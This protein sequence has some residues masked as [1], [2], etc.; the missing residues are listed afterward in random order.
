ME[1]LQILLVIL[2]TNQVLSIQLN[3]VSN[4]ANLIFKKTHNVSIINE[5]KIIKFE[6]NMT[7]FLL[8]TKVL[9]SNIKN[10]SN[11]CNNKTSNINCNYFNRF[12]D[13]NSNRLTNEKEHLFQEKRTKRES[14]AIFSSITNFFPCF[15]NLFDDIINIL[16]KSIEENRNFTSQLIEIQNESLITYRNSMKNLSTD[17]LNIYKKLEKTENE[18]TELKKDNFLNNM[19]ILTIH[20]IEQHIHKTKQILNI[21]NNKQMNEIADF[22]TLQDIDETINKLNKTLQTNEQFIA[23]NS[24]Q[25][26]NKAEIRTKINNTNI[27]IEIEIPTEIKNSEFQL[28]KI[29]SIP[30]KGEGNGEWLKIKTFNSYILHNKH[31]TLISDNFG[32]RSCKTLSD[33]KLLCDLEAIAKEENNCEIQIFLNIQPKLCIF[34]AVNAEAHITRIS[35][36]QFYCIIEKKLNFTTICDGNSTPYYLTQSVWFHAD[37][38]C[39][40]NF[41]E[42]NFTI[43]KIDN[44]K[45]LDIQ[46]SKIPLPEIN[47]EQVFHNISQID[48][49]ILIIRK[50]ITDIRIINNET[51]NIL[52]KLEELYNKTRV[53]P[54]QIESKQGLFLTIIVIIFCL[55]LVKCCLKCLCG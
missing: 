49:D 29:Y 10:I 34:E 47:I 7:N 42:R 55:I 35:T 16:Q 14:N 21:I 17:I 28:Y 4:S 11:I 23:N 38:G 39:I 6:L 41:D 40:I 36:T 45:P 30:F 37:Y 53:K 2:T 22:I 20:A 15:C 32:I 26:I 3:T 13:H 25:I 8:E 50:P 54:T 31:R 1:L 33:T 18:F 12:I 48:P 51:D 27:I 19:I 43:P 24:L 52:R 9:E 5:Y 46:V 44:E